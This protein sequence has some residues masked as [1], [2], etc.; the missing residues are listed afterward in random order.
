MLGLKVNQNWVGYNIRGKGNNSFL[1]IINEHSEV[2]RLGCKEL[3]M[4]T[5][6]MGRKC[7]N[8]LS[9][10]IQKLMGAEQSECNSKQKFAWFC[11][12]CEDYQRK[13]H[14]KQYIWAKD[15]L[16][17]VEESQEERDLIHYLRTW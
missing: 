10:W 4:S 8:M 7:I 14:L 15:V 1:C 5:P 16:M 17:F 9:V 13:L 3:S 11:V 12:R 2:A 6:Q